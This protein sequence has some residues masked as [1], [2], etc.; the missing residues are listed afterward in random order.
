M[1]GPAAWADEFDEDAAVDAG[2]AAELDD[3]FRQAD[4]ALKHQE[5]EHAFQHADPAHQAAMARD[6]TGI[7]QGL[8]DRFMAT[9]DPKMKNSQ[10]MQF[11]SK[12]S[13][14][15]IKFQGNEA[16]EVAPDARGA[17]WADLY[18][19]PGA[20]T[21]GPG[22]AIAEWADDYASA[23]ELAVR[24]AQ[25]SREL[26]D[27]WAADYAEQL[28]RLL[29]PF[30]TTTTP[31]VIKSFLRVLKPKCSNSFVFAMPCY[32]ILV[33]FHSSCMVFVA[34]LSAQVW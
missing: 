20:A 22:A 14:G 27:Q 21:A 3:Y 15:A 19:G 9:A 30:P 31:R 34:M 26:A 17:A 33:V 32:A 16:V 18:A 23:E 25:Q 8:L 7:D 11:L 5:M 10:F 6:S 4:D 13:S 1:A 2:E 24:D 12:V 28:R 29:P